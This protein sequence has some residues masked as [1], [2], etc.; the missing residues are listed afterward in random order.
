MSSIAGLK[1]HPTPALNTS[2][3]NHYHLQQPPSSP[4]HQFRS[5]KTRCTRSPGS[6]KGKKH[7]SSVYRYTPHHSTFIWSVWFAI[8]P[9]QPERRIWSFCARA[10]SSLQM[11]I[12]CWSQNRASLKDTHDNCS[13]CLIAIAITISCRFIV[14]LYRWPGW[15]WR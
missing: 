12:Y 9:T 1:K 6:R 14:Q 2:P 3:H 11:E 8:Y 10:P 7:Q 5:A 13:F 15:W 4:H